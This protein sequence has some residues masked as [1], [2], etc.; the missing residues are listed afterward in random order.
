MLWGIGFQMESTRHFFGLI[1]AVTTGW[2][3]SRGAK[4]RTISALH[5]LTNLSLSRFEQ[6]TTRPCKYSII[7]QVMC[8]LPKTNV[9]WAAFIQFHCRL[10]SC[11]DSA[12]MQI[13]KGPVHT[14]QM[15]T[16]T[17]SAFFSKTLVRV[18]SFE[19]ASFS[20]TYGRTKT[21]VMSNIIYILHDSSSV[22]D[23][24][25]FPSLQR[26]RVNWRT[27]PFLK[28]STYVWTGPW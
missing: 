23:A 2:R 28:V 15:K 5:Y 21:E 20:F 10:L 3:R 9:T 27:S 13:Q 7:S 16:V 22:T 18:D 26:F 24:I 8:S 19:N 6:S 11:F 1:F 12:T 17:E 4:W 25:V 14:Y